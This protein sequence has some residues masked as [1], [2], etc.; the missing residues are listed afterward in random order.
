MAVS[1]DSYLIN[2]GSPERA[3]LI[4]SR[5]AFWAEIERCE[6][7]GILY[8]IFHPGSHVGSGEKAG[9]KMIAN[10]VN[11]ALSKKKGYK[12]QL[13]LETTAGQ[14]TNLGYTFEQLAEILDF[15]KEKDR[16]G[17]C[18]DSCHL[19][20][21]GY[22]IR[23]RKQYQ[24]TM[25]QLDELIGLKRVKAFH[26]NDSKAELGSRVDRH[27]HIGQGHLGLE[28]FRLIVNDERFLGLPMVLETPGTEE[29]YR[30]DLQTLKKLRQTVPMKAKKARM[31]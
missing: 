31:N 19:F 21:A 8:L 22:E 20:A 1:H 13:L 29:D 11:D 4:Q 2:L 27:E 6:Q 12:T 17:I 30:R 18:V 3:K 15:I 25:K 26:L 24:A 16:V 9:L 10:S 23:T 28:T 7:L 14:G 5:E